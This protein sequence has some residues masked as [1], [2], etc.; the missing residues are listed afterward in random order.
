MLRYFRALPTEARVKEM[1]A[2]DYLWC[3]LQ[4]ARDDEEFLARLCPACRAQAQQEG[5]PAC[6]AAFLPPTGG[7]NAQ[8]D[9]G[10]FEELKG[11]A[12]P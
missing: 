7:E 11:G 2:R 1:K 3:L 10:R 4:M 9:L 5:C 6:G 8:F 12:L